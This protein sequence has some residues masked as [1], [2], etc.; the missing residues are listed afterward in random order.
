MIKF[1]DY[2]AKSSNKYNVSKE[3]I[4]ALFKAIC[5]ERNKNISGYYNLPYD[6]EAILDSRKYIKT[7]N[8]FLSSI[9]NLIIIGI[10]GSSLGLKA[11]DSML[12][13][14]QYR[15]DLNLKFLEHTDPI[16][17][18]KSLK[19]IK[20]KNSLF[21]VISKSGK[22][23]ETLSLMKYVLKHYELLKNHNNKKH[24]IFITDKDSPLESFGNLNNITT[25]CINPNIGGRFSVLS[26]IGI[27]PL[28]ILGYRVENI[29]SGAKKLSNSFFNRKEDHILKKAIFFGN[30]R[31]KFHIN[32]LF[33]YSSVFKDFNAW[34][35]QL[36]GE[37]LGKLNSFG[38]KTALTPIALIGSIDQHSFLQLIVQGVMDKTVTF[39]SLHQ[40]SYENPK[41]PKINMKFLDSCDFVN[42]V[43]FAS[44]LQKQQLSTMEAIQKE[45]VPT[46]HIEIKELN[47]ESVGSLIMYYELLTSCAGKVLDIN[48]YNQPGVEFGK[49][50]LITK[51]KR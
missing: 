33:S 9:S 6:K 32:I 38:R 7:N 8:A 41:I 19:K 14:L 5:E 49:K 1:K 51:F 42:G 3:A 35:V 36:W 43:S 12:S 16:K 46:D 28:S 31:D 29:L 22:T 2:F 24:L 13:H 48:A 50:I 39:L 45:G 47:E 11:I 26:T 10:G 23:I 4:N 30:N 40:K 17:I 21:I 25:F 44:L 15:R 20:L 27:L 18:E 34:Y 37:S